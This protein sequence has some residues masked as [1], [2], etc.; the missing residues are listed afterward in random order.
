MEIVSIYAH[1]AAFIDQLRDAIRH[2]SA[3]IGCANTG[4]GK[5]R[6]VKHIFGH[7]LTKEKGEGKSGYILFVVRGRGL[8]YNISDSFNEEPALPHG[9]IMS[10]SDTSPTSRIQVASID[11]VKAWYIDDDGCYDGLTF[12]LI[13]CDEVDMHWPKLE[14]FIKSHARKRAAE[15][16]RET[17]IIGMTATPGVKGLGYIFKQVVYGPKLTW[18]QVQGYSSK[19]QYV[20]GKTGQVAQL[21][22]G[23]NYTENVLAEAMSG[24]EGDFVRDWKQYADGRR[25]IGFFF[26][27]S[28]AMEACHTLREAGVRAEYVDGETSDEERAVLF[29]GLQNHKYDYLCNVGVAGRGTDIPRVACIQLCLPIGNLSTYLQNVGRGSRVHPDK[30]DCLVLDHGGNVLRHGFWSDDREWQLLNSKSVAAEPSP[31][32]S[33]EC[34]QCHRI[35]R[36]GSCEECGYEPAASEL[37]EFGLLFD[38]TEL[39]EIKVS[40]PAK[41]KPDHEKILLS[42]IYKGARSRRGPMNWGQVLRLFCREVERQ[43]DK[44][45][46]PASFVVRGDR[47]EV[48]SY[49]DRATK[50]RLVTQLFPDLFDL[51]R[52]AK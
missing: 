1:Q 21:T 7:A 25:T 37:K 23:E 2:N 33:V 20:A 35:Y 38:G 22:A 14:L 12:D 8:V 4:F 44:I 47:I 49:G 18:L 28:Q 45:S 17:T 39:K 26:R 43:G 16:L 40:P 6:C 32:P 27:R 13:V 24:L 11:T 3:V 31:R 30:S 5:T 48:P 19:F 50:K 51:K 42:S 15:S 34:P 10:K 41:K 52:K 36:G 9:V 29:S 46:W